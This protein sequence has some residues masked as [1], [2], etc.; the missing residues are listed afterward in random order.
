MKNKIYALLMLIMI[1]SCDNEPVEILTLSSE[2]AIVSF[3]INNVDASINETDKT[4]TLV[5]PGG[6]DITS[7]SPMI[8][9]SNTATISPNSDAAQDFSTPVIYTVTAADTSTVTY[10]VNVTTGI[11]LSAEKEITSFSINSV[12]ATINETAK[13]VMITLP[14][15]T[16]ATS[17]SPTIVISN[18]ATIS[19]NSGVAQDFTNPVIYTVTAEDGSSVNYTV[20]V[21][22]TAANL[23]NEKQITSFSI[24]SVNGTINETAKTVMI[25]LPFGTDA[26]SLSPTIV[27]SNLAT[28]SPNSGV[29]QDFTNPVVYTVTAEDS[30]S[31]N[32]TITVTV[33]QSTCADPSNIYTFTYN[34]K[35][36]ELVRENKNWA[37]AA[38]CAA[39]RGGYLAEIN[40]AAENAAIFNELMNNAGIVLS[41]TVSNSGGAASYVFLGGN[42]IASEG[43]WVWNGNN[44]AN[45]TQF[46]Q[47]DASGTPVGGLYNNWG[48]EPDNF[49]GNQDALG[50]GL[51]VWPQ[52]V[53]GLGV[54][55]EWND[56]P[57]SD[58]L[59]YLIEFD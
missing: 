6:T 13:T 41:N 52:P 7:L 32:Y 27:I 58:S 39:E 53:G 5:L 20:T 26:T 10:T 18:L 3:S 16:D 1:S 11:A 31:V 57:A 56:I 51:N 42:D 21:T 33:T 22:V 43:V 35:I 9:I 54:A 30:S 59:Y 15:G 12:N 50:I 2:K 46:W 25:T 14:F 4:I 19:P 55:G 29:A 45:T 36:Y 23:S 24:N 38:A 17:L 34:G 44:D 48:V 49:A 8:A 47:G 37:A 40:D 28:I